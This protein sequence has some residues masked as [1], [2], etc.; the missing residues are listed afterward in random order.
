MLLE[1]VSVE[2]LRDSGKGLIGLRTGCDR[3]VSRPCFPCGGCSWR[4]SWN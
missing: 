1:R 3:T 4:D 2:S